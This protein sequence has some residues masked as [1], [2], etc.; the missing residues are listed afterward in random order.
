ME[1]VCSSGVCVQANVCGN[2]I[3][4]GIEVCD[5]ANEVAFDCCDPSCLD[6]CVED[7]ACYDGNPCNGAATC[8]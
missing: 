6:T 7:S 3:V 8:A 2:G 1:L 4:E 5:D